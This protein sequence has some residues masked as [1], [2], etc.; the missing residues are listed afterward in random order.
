MSNT[1]FTWIAFYSELA[2][3]LLAYKSDRAT[4]IKLITKAFADAEVELPRLENSAPTDIDPFTVYGLFNKMN[5]KGE[6][7]K[8]IMCSL[9]LG[10]GVT[11]PIPTDFDGVP[12]LFPMSATFYRFGDENEKNAIDLLWDVFEKALKYADQKNSDNASAFVDAFDGAISLPFVRWKLTIGLY[13]ARPYS[14]INLD[15]TNKDFIKNT[16]NIPLSKSITAEEYLTLIGR[17]IREIEGGIHPFHSLPELSHIAWQEAKTPRHE[18][19]KEELEDNNNIEEESTVRYWSYSPGERAFMWDRFYSAGIMAIGWGEIGNLL[20]FKTREDMI[21]KM[22]E[23]FGDDVP[24]TNASLATWEFANKLNPGDIVFAKRGMS[25]IVGCGIVMSEYEYHSERHDDF[26]HV[27]RIKWTHRG[28]WITPNK[29]AQK[30]LTD[31]TSNNNLVQ[32]LLELIGA[33]ELITEKTLDT[34]KEPDASTPTPYTREDFLR[35]VYIDGDMYDE[36]VAKLMRKK[37]IILQ[38]P[39]GVGKTYAAD[40]LAYSIMGYKD[41]TRVKMIQFHQSYSYEDFI[42]GYRPKENGFEI[43]EGPFY[44]FCKEAEKHPELPYFFIIDEINRGNLSKIFGELFMLVEGDKRHKRLS[45]LYRDEEFGVP[46]NLYIIGMMNTADR[47]LAMID[48]ALRRRFAFFTFHPAFS[49]KGFANYLEKKNSE[50]LTRVIGIIEELNEIITNDDTL[51][52]GFTIGHSYFCTDDLVDEGWL[53][54][55]INYEIAPLLEEYWFD[56]P[57]KCDKWVRRLREALK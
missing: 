54:S 37:N 1:T 47:S 25:V 56:E 39:P 31:I 51:G 48:F 44:R 40:R 53:A 16:L 35:D 15:N 50:A 21:S 19:P 27:R 52:R 12:V 4:L 29:I 46:E 33:T 9:G 34:V 45:L 11:S 49:S 17:L 8:A 5:L 24:Y 32:S 6:K 55:V 26:K 41:L 3:K 42:M 14:Y 23:T 20:A 30:T 38:G 28:E 18:S 22:K 57:D 43:V 2:N 13:W 36:L 7:R 10:L